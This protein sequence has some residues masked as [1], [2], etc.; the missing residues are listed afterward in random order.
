MKNLI[1]L[2]TVLTLFSNCNNLQAQ[3]QTDFVLSNEEIIYSF[4]TKSGKKMV[5]VKDKNNAYMQYRFGSQNK[6]EL[7]FPTEKTKE[8]WQKFEYNSYWRGGGVENSGMEIDNLQFSNNGYTYLVYRTYFAEGE[9]NAAGIIIT[10]SKGKEIRINGMPET[11]QGCICN[12]E[13]TRNDRKNRYWIIFLKK[14]RKQIT[15]RTLFIIFLLA[16]ATQTYAQNQRLY[17]G[18]INGTLKVTLYLEGL[19]EGTNADR[20]LGAYIYENQNEYILL[21]GYR[22]KD[23]NIVLVEQATANFSGVF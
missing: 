13:H 15:M 20:I 1:L 12:L 9:K 22:N 8:S 4:E 17:K 23:G 6:I 10:D 7:E 3:K 18:T 5:L 2:F 16:A 11:I 19:D 14:I 21:N